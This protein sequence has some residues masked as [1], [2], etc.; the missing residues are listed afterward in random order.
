MGSGGSPGGKSSKG[1]SP[2]GQGCP[3]LWASHWT[4]LCD[5]QCLGACSPSGNGSS[6]NGSTHSA[7][8]LKS[9]LKDLYP[10][11][12]HYEAVTPRLGEPDSQTA[13][14]T[15]GWGEGGS[16]A[17]LNLPSDAHNSTY[18]FSVPGTQWQMGGTWGSPE[19]AKLKGSSLFKSEIVAIAQGSLKYCCSF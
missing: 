7:V 18:S 19:A 11:T 13:A 15:P 9:P 16:Q 3:W 12:C 5:I 17:H 10:P 6:V 4:V 8:S 14:Q 1:S 2:R